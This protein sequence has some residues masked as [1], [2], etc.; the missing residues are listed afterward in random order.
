MR[1]IQRGDGQLFVSEVGG[2]RLLVGGLVNDAGFSPASYQSYVARKSYSQ[3]RIDYRPLGQNWFVLSGE[4]NGQIFYEKVIFSCGGRLINSFALLYP[5]DARA[6][7]DRIVERME[8]SFRPG[9]N[10]AQAG[11]EAPA[12]RGAAGRRT[13][14]AGPRYERSVLADRIARARGHDV[15]VVLRRTGWPYDYKIVL[16]HAG[17]R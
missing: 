11:L 12:T 2:A 1:V 16:G 5:T 17:L 9:H 8:K 13:V 15:L 14:P 10:C 6:A 4:G 7:F 3:Y